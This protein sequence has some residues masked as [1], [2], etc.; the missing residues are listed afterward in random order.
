M[1]Q[2]SGAFADV[3]NRNRIGV[4]AETEEGGM[5]EA[6]NA[7]VAPDESKTEREDAEDGV[8]R[9][10]KQREEIERKRQSDQ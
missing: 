9:D 5:S 10:L 8:E 6:E 1:Q 3:D 2:R 4:G 7:A